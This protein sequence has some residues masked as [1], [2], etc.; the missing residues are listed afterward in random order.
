MV[1]CSE[2]AVSLAFHVCC[3]YFSAVL[4]VGVP[5]PFGFWGRMWNSIEVVSDHCRFNFGLIVHFNISETPE[6]V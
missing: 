5:F 4:I 6:E 1:I 3:F 2:R